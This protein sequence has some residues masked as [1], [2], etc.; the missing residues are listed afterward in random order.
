MRITEGKIQQIKEAIEIVE[1]IGGYVTLKKRGRTYLGLCPFHNEKTPSFNVN[2]ERGVFKCFGCGEG[3][4]AIS[5]VMK[6]E[7]LTYPETLKILAEKYHIELD[8]QETYENQ[9]QANATESLYIV[10]HFAQD[11][12]VEQLSSSEGKIALAYLKERGISDEMIRKFGL[13]YSFHDHS[14]TTTALK[15]QYEMK[16][17][18]ETGLCIQNEEKTKIFDRFKERVMFPIHSQSGKVLGFGGRILTNDKK[19]AKYL[20]S[21][22][23]P[24]YEK[25]KILYGLF[26]ARQA[27]RKLDECILTEGYTDVIALH[28]AGL[29]NVVSSS[30]TSLTEEQIKLIKKHTNNILLVFDGD[31]AGIKAALRGLDLILAQGL[32]LKIIHLPEGEDP[33]SFSKKNG[34]AYVKEYFKTHK[35]DG[36]AFKLDVLLEGVENDPI[37]RSEVQREMLG[38]ITK[39]PDVIIQQEYV[40]YVA[41]RLNSDEKILTQE[42]SKLLFNQAKKEEPSLEFVNTDNL[43][44]VQQQLLESIEVTEQEEEI[45]RLLLLYGA[46]FI[47][48]LEITLFQLLANESEGI[49]IEHPT[50]KLLYD[51]LMAEYQLHHSINLNQFI[52]HPNLEIKNIVIRLSIEKYKGEYSER[53]LKMEGIDYSMDNNLPKSLQNAVLYLQLKNIRELIEENR[54]N[55][56]QAQDE[57]NTEA[58]MSALQI[59]QELQKWKTNIAKA[60]GTVVY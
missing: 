50:Y 56:K 26:F 2:P 12:F 47:P 28:Q 38:S 23:S 20:N 30:G 24:I 17:L 7:Q 35:K 31:S 39:I 54:Q 1:V 49:S 59:Q 19:Q 44:N 21:P 34:S 27:I 55:L 53:W 10:N 3:G 42:L 52:E 58:M 48:E 46:S 43:T 14:L 36:L 18:L 57:K 51:E 16:Y 45:V 13:G 40:K 5:F 41:K 8:W 33:D 60:L 25:S 29:D 4:D 6:H 9:E 15:K 22:E 11:L 37:K 32:T